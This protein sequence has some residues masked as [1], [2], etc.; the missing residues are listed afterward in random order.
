LFGEKNVEKIDLPNGL[1]LLLKADRRLPFIEMRAVLRGGVLAETQADNGITQLTAKMLLQG[2]RNRSAEEIATQIESIG[3]SIDTFGGFNSFGVSAEVLSADFNTGLDIF[4]DVLLHPSFPPDAFEGEQRIQLEILRAQR[5]HLLQSCGRSMRRAMFG[6]AGYGLDP[7]GEE[8]SV[9][10]LTPA[11]LAA[12]HA[13]LT[14]PNNCV[15]AI[16]GDIDIAATRASIEKLFADW[17]PIPNPPGPPAA[18][19]PL[20]QVRRVEEKRD[21]KQAVILMSFVGTSIDHPDHYALDLL[22]E[23]CSDL[24]SR[25][26]IRIRDNLGLAYYVGAQNFLGLTPGYFAFYAGTAPEQAAQVQDELLKEV[27]L[28]RTEGVTEDELR[29]AKAK[30]IGQKKIA[31]QDMGNLAMTA[32]LDELYGMGYNRID[33]EDKEY[34][35][36]TLAQVQA[37]AQKYLKP[38]AFVMSIIQP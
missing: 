37:V 19:A 38:D 35:A 18:P 11:D 28:L 8:A 36:T 17:R 33:I 15:L 4:T 16:F 26:F 1:R 10:K 24:G 20:D 7:S 30:L 21:K 25:L 27:Q 23:T 14:A 31:R 3:G 2:T 13:K 9:Q 22:Q 32:A 5:D 12:F 34:Q 29:R 6:T